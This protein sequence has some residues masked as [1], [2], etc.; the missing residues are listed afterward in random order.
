[1]EGKF[2]DNEVVNYLTGICFRELSKVVTWEFLEVLMIKSIANFTI[3]VSEE[4][5]SV[6]LVACNFCAKELILSRYLNILMQCLKV[7]FLS[8][9]DLFEV[10]RDPEEKE[11]GCFSRHMLYVYFA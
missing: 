7:K 2:D 5:I 3:P 1:M 11:L 4:V 8:R 10:G 6:E 9:M